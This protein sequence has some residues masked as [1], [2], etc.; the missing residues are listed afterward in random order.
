MIE[1]QNKWNILME[2]IR[3]M[4]R[5]HDRLNAQDDM[6]IKSF[7]ADG[8]IAEEMTM[9]M[10]K[11]RPIK[12]N[13]GNNDNNDESDDNDEATVIAMRMKKRNYNR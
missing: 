1:R 10:R 13:A 4:K 9:R 2:K 5:D 6:S 11:N 7:K 8:R 12:R 3:D